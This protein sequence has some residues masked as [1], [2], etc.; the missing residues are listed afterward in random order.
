MGVC[1]QPDGFTATNGK[2]RM[3]RLGCQLAKA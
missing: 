1:R 3:P 2:G